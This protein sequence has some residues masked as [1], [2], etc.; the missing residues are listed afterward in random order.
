MSPVE[1]GWAHSAL[2]RALRWMRAVNGRM[3]FGRICVLSAEL[4]CNSKGL[5]T[6]LGNWNVGMGLRVEFVIAPLEMIGS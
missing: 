6:I 4:N 2:P 3:I 5:V 1:D